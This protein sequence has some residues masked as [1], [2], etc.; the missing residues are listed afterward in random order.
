MQQHPAARAR[1]ATPRARQGR[2][3]P[4]RPP[5]LPAWAREAAPC[6]PAAPRYQGCPAASAASCQCG[7]D[8]PR[9]PSLNCPPSQS[10][11]RSPPL[12]SGQAFFSCTRLQSPGPPPGSPWTPCCHPLCVLQRRGA[13]GVVPPQAADGGQRW[14]RCRSAR[15][16]PCDQDLRC[17]WVEGRARQAAGE[18]RRAQSERG[19]GGRPPA[20]VLR[21]AAACWEASPTPRLPSAAGQPAALRPSSARRVG[22]SGTTLFRPSCNERHALIPAQ[23]PLTA[24]RH[25]PHTH[26]IPRPRAAVLK[27]HFSAV[28]SLSLSPDGW[29][30]LS[31]GRDSVVTVWSMR[32]FSKVA[33]V[34]VFEALEGEAGC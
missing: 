27:A 12:V 23:H 25:P 30:L 31:G 17:R 10:C 16:G 5:A 33:T 20:C 19:L 8:M 32:D 26:L 34:P 15:V 6:P 13:A 2:R 14:R 22:C 4:F 29:T 28:T 11:A 1:A 24:H 7:A 3:G 9:P 21:R 18:L